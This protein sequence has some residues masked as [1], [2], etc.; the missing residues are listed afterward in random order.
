MDERSGP[1]PRRIFRTKSIRQLVESTGG[2]HALKRVLNPFE[3]V[4]FGIGAVVGT[5]IFV[6]TGVAAAD[7]AGPAVVVSF[8][9][10]AIVCLFAALCYAEFAAMVPVAGSAYTYSY[11]SL[12]EIWAWI[13]G[14]DLF[15]EYSVAVA[16]VAIGWSGYVV[17]LLGELGITLPA[18]LVN[19]P[20]VAGG[21]INLP[22]ILIIAAI[23]VLLILG[24]KESARINAVIV[25]IKVAVILLFLYLGFSRID[26][27]NWS[28]F[29]PYGWD[30]VVTG[31]AIVFFAY[32]GFD[33]VSTTAE[34]V[35][36][37]RR[38]LPIGL[39]GSL[40]VAT[41]LYIAASLV[42]TGIVPYAELNVPA[43][44]S[45][46]PSTGS[47]SP[48]A[49]CSSPSGHCS[50]SPRCYSSFSSVRPGSSSR[51][52]EIGRASCRE[53]VY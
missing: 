24:V 13:I 21:L 46:S 23:T 43:P 8:V 12:G 51:C 37:P 7:F 11:A 38:D 44:R 26:P 3:L 27:S 6:I 9:V 33:A 15:L 42:L 40:L 1:A 28:P 5:G 41:A 16:A 34:E 18:A 53:R 45:P 10:S 47:V 29:L 25:A 31:A 48:G 14:W 22:A 39:I 20:G 52:P 2:E 19:P 36:N 50:G 49:G 30:G 4:L 35:R 32:I 17:N